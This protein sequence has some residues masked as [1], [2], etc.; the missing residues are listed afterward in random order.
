MN[1]FIVASALLALSGCYEV[2]GPDPAASTSAPP[3]VDR[4]PVT[5]G[6]PLAVTGVRDL[7]T[8]DQPPRVSGRVASTIETHRGVRWVFAEVGLRGDPSDARTRLNAGL[9]TPAHGEPARLVEALDRT[10]APLEALAYQDGDRAGG[11]ATGDAPLGL[12]PIAVA[13]PRADETLVFYGRWRLRGGFLNLGAE[14]VSIARYTADGAPMTRSANLLYAP[15]EPAYAP[16]AIDGDTVYLARC[17]VV[18]DFDAACRM[19]RVARGAVESR[20][21]YTYWDGAGWSRDAARATEM[22]RGANGFT[23]GYNR[24]L[25]RW[26]AVYGEVLGNRMFVRTAARPEGPWDAPVLALTTPTPSRDNNYA[27]VSHP[28]LSDPAG[29]SLVV[30]WF[31]PRGEAGGETHVAELSF[32]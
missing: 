4:C 24:H 10:G 15:G 21:A 1:K 8:L 28:A 30:S 26:V 14:G 16:V 9:A 25:A 29:C 19:A 11:G 20:A 5:P 7:G 2:V 31:A 18:N 27:M 22:V 12:W 23:M 3:P 32:R 6:A 17:E 13:V